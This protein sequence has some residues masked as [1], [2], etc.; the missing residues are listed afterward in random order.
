MKNRITV[1]LSPIL[2]TSSK[3]AVAMLYGRKEQREG[4]HEGSESSRSLKTHGLT[5]LPADHFVDYKKHFF[6]IHG[7]GRKKK[8]KV[9]EKKKERT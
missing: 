4:S 1:S 6:A 7:Y 3:N 8:E 2:V 5:P 9:K